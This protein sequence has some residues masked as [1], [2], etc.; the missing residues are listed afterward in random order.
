[1]AHPARQSVP[2]PTA[3]L[4]PWTNDQ[5]TLP[6]GSAVLLRGTPITHGIHVDDGRVALGLLGP[7]GLAHTLGR[8]EGPCWLDPGS[9]VLGLAPLMDIVAETPVRVR[10]VPLADFSAIYA[11]LD[12]AEDI[13][14]DA[15]APGDRIFT[16]G[17]QAY[18][19][20]GGRLAAG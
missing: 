12:G 1:M 8:L 4:P 16:C 7:E 19:Q 10:A 15:M 11:R 17:T 14:I 5:V 6:P 3:V 18:A 20:R 9:A 13:A 2:M